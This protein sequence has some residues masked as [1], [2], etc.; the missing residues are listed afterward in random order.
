MAHTY[1]LSVYGYMIADAARTD[2]Y[3]EALRQA[4]KPGAV[5][6]DI[7]TGTG[8]FALMAC[9]CGAA[10]VYAVDPSEFVDLAR[11]LA[12]VNGYADRIHFIQGISTRINLPEPVDVVVS[13]LHGQLSFF[14]HLIPTI[15]DARRRL[16][17]PGGHLIPREDTV[18]A[19]VVEVPQVYENLTSI[20][21]ENVY[22]LDLRPARALAINGGCTAHLKPENLLAPAQIWWKLD[23]YTVE[24]PDA[25]AEL[26]WKITRSG[27]AH[28]IALWFDSLLAPGISYSNR[29]GED[30][31]HGRSLLPWPEPVALNA[32]DQVT[33]NLAAD[34]V[35]SDYL[36]RWD[37]RILEQG[38]PERV[39]AEFRQSTFEATVFS[40]ATLRQR[41]AVHVP[42]LTEDG[43][44]ERFI[45]GLMDGKNSL[46]EIARRLRAEF[47]GRFASEG[48]ALGLVG[49]LSLKYGRSPDSKY[50]RDP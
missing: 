28:G 4:V 11:Q 42:V 17:A 20:W 7:G 6:L 39:K 43:R 9:Q 12:A 34:L 35:G 5:V 45:L 49:D 19:A 10:R 33:V 48:E 22:G 47:P 30:R 38:R 23:F 41:A 21:R 13:E 1:P 18:W 40:P 50:L 32:G 25:Q 24:Q 44:T 31:V 29:P 15:V 3:L 16:L 46:G 26:T 14:E 37:T 2:G 27:T 8:I 36:W